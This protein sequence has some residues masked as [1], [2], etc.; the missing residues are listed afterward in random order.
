M[1]FVLYNIRYATGVKM[2]DYLRPS[3]R[4]LQRITSFLGELQPD[5]V[6]LI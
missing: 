4:N 3:S 5:L 2:H 1:R 6:G